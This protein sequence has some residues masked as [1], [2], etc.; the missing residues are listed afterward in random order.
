MRKEVEGQLSIFDV[1]NIEEPKPAKPKK[2]KEPA[3]KY[4]WSIYAVPRRSYYGHFET[5]ISAYSQ[6]QAVFLFN[7]MYQGYEVTGIY[8]VN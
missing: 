1:Y 7:K 8:R 3:I 2:V 5:V 6:K 4:L